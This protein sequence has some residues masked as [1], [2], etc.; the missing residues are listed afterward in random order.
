MVRALPLFGGVLRCSGGPKWTETVQWW[1]TTAEVASPCRW[2]TLAFVAGQNVAATSLISVKTSPS[3]RRCVG[4]AHC[5]AC[6]QRW[7]TALKMTVI[8]VGGT[9]VTC[10]HNGWNRVGYETANWGLR[11]LATDGM[12]RQVFAKR[13]LIDTVTQWQSAFSP[14]DRR[15]IA[16]SQMGAPFIMPLGRSGVGPEIEIGWLWIRCNASLLIGI[17]LPCRFHDGSY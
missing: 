8:F 10:S 1:T 2:R 3:V 5:K 15:P 16:K 17:I 6:L 9:A 7:H 14:N 11:S 12:G 13:S 4:H